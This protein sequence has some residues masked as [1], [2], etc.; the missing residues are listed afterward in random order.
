ME[1]RKLN[2]KAIKSRIL[3]CTYATLKDMLFALK[4]TN[5]VMTSDLDPALLF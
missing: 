4:E 2:I 3:K 1:Y 5:I